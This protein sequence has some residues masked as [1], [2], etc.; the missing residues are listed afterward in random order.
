M[1]YLRGQ[2]VIVDPVEAGSQSF[3]II[4]HDVPDSANIAC[5][6]ITPPEGGEVRVASVGTHRLHQREHNSGLVTYMTR[7]HAAAEQMA[8]V[9]ANSPDLRDAYERSDPKHPDYLDDLLDRAD[10]R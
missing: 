10:D 1:Q 3:G 7:P 2:H 6:A 9:T 8:T 5:V 4:Q